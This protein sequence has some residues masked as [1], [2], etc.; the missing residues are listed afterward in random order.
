MNMNM[1]KVGELL[2]H[3]DELAKEE[4]TSAHGSLECPTAW[5]HRQSGSTW[6]PSPERETAR[7]APRWWAPNVLTRE[8]PH[9]AK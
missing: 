5:E 9:Q 6:L 4:G 3:S 2:E 8:L 1:S 7:T